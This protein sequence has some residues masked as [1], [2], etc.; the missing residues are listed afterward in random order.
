MLRFAVRLERIP[1]SNFAVI[2]RWLCA[3]VVAIV[4]Y[5]VVFAL[6]AMIWK[7]F[8]GNPVDTLYFS[9]AAATGFGVIVGTTTILPREKW[10]TAALALWLIALL[11]P[12]WGLVQSVLTGSAG[13]SNF[14][15]FGGAVL[16]GL[17]VFYAVRAGASG[18]KINRVSGQNR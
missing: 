14:M 13:L 3:L 12:L 8:G 4:V 15:E 9:I 1:V 16:G 11:V 18:G 5:T 10:K 17:M 6:A 2:L 7:Q